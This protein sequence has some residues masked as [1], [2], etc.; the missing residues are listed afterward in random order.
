VL[1]FCARWLKRAPSVGLS[2]REKKGR[3]S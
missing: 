3:L 2:E 1:V